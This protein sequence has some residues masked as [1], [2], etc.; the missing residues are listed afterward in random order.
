[1]PCRRRPAKFRIVYSDP[2]LS[3]L[4]VSF[5]VTKRFFAVAH[6]LLPKRMPSDMSMAFATFPRRNFSWAKST[7]SVSGRI[8]ATPLFALLFCSG[9]SAGFHGKI[10][11]A[12][13]GHRSPRLGDAPIAGRRRMLEHLRHRSTVDA[14]PLR[15]PS[16]AHPAAK[17]REP[18]PPIQIHSEHTPPPA[19]SSE[20]KAYRWRDFTPPD[21]GYSDRFGGRLLRCRSQLM[22]PS[23]GSEHGSRQEG[24]QTGE[25][26]D[27]EDDQKEHKEEGRRALDQIDEGIFWPKPL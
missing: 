19:R 1:M 27:Q 10:R 23:S 9:V 14:E 4:L 13:S 26:N 12:G 16:P 22:V 25:G 20:L 11:V 8:V 17:N 7:V 21:S 6:T 18:N 3:G 5:A 24:D 15:R 2:N